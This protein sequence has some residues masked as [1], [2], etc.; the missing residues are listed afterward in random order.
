MWL[1][2]TCHRVSWTQMLLKEIIDFKPL[3]LP[4]HS[5]YNTF[6]TRIALI[7]TSFYNRNNSLLLSD[8]KL[9]TYILT[10]FVYFFL[11]P[12]SVDGMTI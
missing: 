6:S 7:E 5:Q 10:R 2:V 4:R 8:V 11:F 9:H 3:L 12:N 1:W